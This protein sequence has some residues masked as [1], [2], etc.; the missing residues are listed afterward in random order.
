M[1]RKSMLF[2]VVCM[3]L[4]L[5]PSV[6]MLFFPTTETTENK[7]MAQLPTLMTQEGKLNASFLSGLETYLNEH[8]ALRNQLVYADAMI[9]SGLFQE[10]NVSGVID[11]TDGWL[12]YSSTLDDYLGTNVL[13]DRLLFNLANNFLVIQEYVQQRDMEFVLTIAPN[14]NTLYPEY[15]PYYKSYIV[16]P[17]HSAQLLAPYLQEK[18]VAY[19]DLFALFEEQEEILYLLRDSHWNRKGACLVYNAIMDDLG[20]VHED[21]SATQPT[22]VKNEN[23]DLNKMLY[24]F[25]G[26][27]EE[28]YDYGLTQQY[29]YEKEGATVEDGWIITHNPEGNGKLLMLRDSFANTLIPFFSNEFASAY[30]SKG[31]PNA[32]ERFVETYDPDCVV[33]EKVERNITDYLENPPILTAPQAQL[34]ENLTI[35]KSNST[36]MVEESMND[37]NYYKFT[38]AVDADRLADDSCIWVSVNDNVYRAYLTGENAYLLYLKKD[39]FTQAQADLRVYVVNGDT[40]TQVLTQTLALEG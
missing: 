25:Y 8:M 19:R 23:G 38:G 14:K 29:T 33:I 5:I 9:Q 18:S 6:G 4:C 31:L 20:Y 39:A 37:V 26:A 36:I 32:L 10:S 3:V 27:Q 16:Q 17:E 13:S 21:Y 11:G 28:N 1:K 7:A 22:L 35:A 30:Y 12:Y 15:M 24:S 40:C 34:P 2:L